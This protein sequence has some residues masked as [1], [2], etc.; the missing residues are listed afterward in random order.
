MRGYIECV[1]GLLIPEDCRRVWL[2]AAYPGDDVHTLSGMFLGISEE[3]GNGKILNGDGKDGQNEISNNMNKI[4]SSG[5]ASLKGLFCFY[6]LQTA[7]DCM[8]LAV[9]AVP[10]TSARTA[11]SRWIKVRNLWCSPVT[12]RGAYHKP[13]SFVVGNREGEV[14][15]LLSFWTVPQFL[16]N[17]EFKKQLYVMFKPFIWFAWLFCSVLFQNY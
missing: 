5:T 8:Y 7:P 2:S 9:T 10:S 14:K 17:M 11:Q 1:R 6:I 15:L 4:G 3:R 16:S 13:S 12:L